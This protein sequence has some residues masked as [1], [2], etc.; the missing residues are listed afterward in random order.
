MPLKR[1]RAWKRGTVIATL[2]LLAAMLPAVADFPERNI[3]LV[4]PFAAG[5]STD[6]IARIVGDHMARTLGRS[7]I[8]ENDAGA[9][10]TTPAKRV[11][12]AAPDGYTLIIG[13]LGT[14]S[15]TRS[16][17]PRRRA[18]PTAA[19]AAIGFVSAQPSCDLGDND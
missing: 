16:W 5:G 7:I 12:Q 14:P 8:V 11:A 9:G 6:T 17:V 18:L 15:C 13:N 1:S 2:A 4:V 10:G 19:P 3:T